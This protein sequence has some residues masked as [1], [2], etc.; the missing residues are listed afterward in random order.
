VALII[1]AKNHG[2]DLGDSLIVTGSGAFDN[3][4]QVKHQS[5]SSIGNLVW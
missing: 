4:I 2:V 3:G 1:D 5:F